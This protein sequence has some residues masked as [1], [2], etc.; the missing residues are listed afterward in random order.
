MKVRG[1]SA[2]TLN[3]GRVLSSGFNVPGI[4][5]PWKLPRRVAFCISITTTRGLPG[6][7]RTIYDHVGR[8]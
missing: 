3:G 8:I 2:A 1:R 4:L 6:G 7:V 5:C